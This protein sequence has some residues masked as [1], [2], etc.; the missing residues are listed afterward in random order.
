MKNRQPQ[1]RTAFAVPLKR[2]SG[3]GNRQYFQL[4]IIATRFDNLV[5]LFRYNFILKNMK[6]A[7]KK[8]KKKGQICYETYQA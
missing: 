1:E 4:N 3:I 6:P 5:T 7:L 8:K 2:S